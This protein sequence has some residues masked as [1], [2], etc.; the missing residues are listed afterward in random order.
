M[1]KISVSPPGILR[2]LWFRNA[3]ELVGSVHGWLGEGYTWLKYF[4]GL[5]FKR[6]S[7]GVSSIASL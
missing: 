2:E 4:Y 7:L 3:G 1:A 6:H 5:I